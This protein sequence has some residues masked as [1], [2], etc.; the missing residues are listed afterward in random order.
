ML[1]TP[2]VMLRAVAASRNAPVTLRT[3]SVTLRTPSVMLRTPSVMLRAV[4][5]SRQGIRRGPAEISR[6]EVSRLKSPGQA[7]DDHLRYI[8]FFMRFGRVHAE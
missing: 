7:I 1:R 2:S 8:K 5:A 3:P 6:P 4:A